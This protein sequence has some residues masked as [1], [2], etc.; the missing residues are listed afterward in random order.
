[1]LNARLIVVCLLLVP[2]LCAHAADPDAWTLT[3]ADF[4]QQT[5]V[6]TS[7]DDHTLSAGV[8][9]GEPSRTIP[10]TQFLE[11][12][13]NQPP[14][15]KPAGRFVLHLLSG[16]QLVGDPIQ[17][18]Q[19]KLTWNNPI[20]GELSISLRQIVAIDRVG[21]STSTSTD[22]R[23]DDVITLA[24][25]DTLHG[26]LTLL[27]STR[28][29]VQPA[30]GET[31]TVPLESVVRIAFA[32]IATPKSS[33]EPAF[34]LRFVDGS[35]LVVRSIHLANGRVQIKFADKAT[36]DIPLGAINAIEQL[37]GPVVWLSKVT[38]KENVQI[39]YFSISLPAQMDRNVLGRPIRYADR[40]Y[41]HGIG[42]HS[43]SRLV[44]ALEGQFATFRTQ[45]AIDTTD[46]D[47][48]YADV[49]VKILLD[50]KVVH[51]QAD[52]KAGVLSPVV[53]IP[54]SGASTLTLE[55]D[56]GQ[57]MDVQDRFNWIEPALLRR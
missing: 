46:S 24:N 19:E 10:L 51:E 17:T 49:T 15:P 57:T 32:A 48:R 2:S 37:N 35:S 52:F 31:A 25:G 41:T 28:L 26:I 14:V 29:V 54:L 53:L 5:L 45:Y 18:Q 22:P 11:L 9:S 50:G 27:D 39:P 33:T 20:V 23:M 43:Y 55:V 30:S 6:P 1:M 40:I 13:R 56:Y 44:Y 12:E 7:I 34:R 21:Q 16:D 8:Q 42:V 4:K 47:G 36:R 38:P 3:T